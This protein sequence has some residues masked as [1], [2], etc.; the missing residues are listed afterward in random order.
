MRYFARRYRCIAFNARG[1]PPSEVPQDAAG[2]SQ[3]RA[4]RRHPLRPRRAQD[5]QGAHRR[6]V[7]GRVRDASLRADLSQPRPLAAGRRCRLRVREKRAREVPQRGN[8]SSPASSRRTG[9]PPSPRPM[10]TARRACSSRTRT[11]AG[12]PSSRPCWASIRPRVPPT[13]SSACSA[14]A[15]RSSIWR[16][17]WPSSRCQCWSSPATRTGRACCRASSSSARCPSAALLVVPN[18]GHAINIEEPGGLQC[19]AGRFPRPGRHR[20]LAHARSPRRQPEHHRHDEVATA[21]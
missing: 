14:S 13:P 11:R 7:D 15:P 5:R 9:W 12:S 17:S 4:L 16:T 8:A 3:A 10:R 20:P 1:W 18:S 2:Y 19:G 6:P 21:I